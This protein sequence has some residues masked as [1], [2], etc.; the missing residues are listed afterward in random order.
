MRH[1][2]PLAA[3]LRLAAVLAVPSVLPAVAAE[4]PG[5]LDLVC[6]EQPMRHV[7]FGPDGQIGYGEQPPR[8]PGAVAVSVIRAE[9]RGGDTSDAA[10]IESPNADL[11]ADQATW[12]DGFQVEARQGHLRIDLASQVLTLAE[13]GTA[14]EATFRRFRCEPRVEATSAGGG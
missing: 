10:R 6:V 8:A 4:L 1:D 2:R 14:G 7:S 11:A 3:V 9:Q 12:I 13:T 5:R